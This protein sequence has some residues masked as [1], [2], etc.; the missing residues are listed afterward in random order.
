[1]VADADGLVAVPSL[2]EA[3][4]SDDVG[5]LTLFARWD[6]PFVMRRIGICHQRLDGTYGDPDA[7]VEV[8]A[9][10]GE[11]VTWWCEETET[12]CAVTRTWAA[13]ADEDLTVEV[14]RRTWSLTLVVDGV[15]AVVEEVPVGADVDLEALA[16][17]LGIDDDIVSWHLLSPQGGP[18]LG[19]RDTVS[20]LV[21]AG[22]ACVLEARF[23]PEDVTVAFLPGC[24]PGEVRGEMPDLVVAADEGPLALPAC[25]YARAGFS[26]VGW[27]CDAAADGVVHDVGEAVDVGA[28][29][30]ERVGLVAVWEPCQVKVSV[31]VLAA[32]GV[33]GDAGACVRRSMLT[34]END[35]DAA[36]ELAGVDVATTG[37][38][39]LV[40]WGSVV[41]DTDVAL[42]LE[43]ADGS[44]YDLSRGELMPDDSV[45][46]EEGPATLQVAILCETGTIEAEGELCSLRWA[47]RVAD[48]GVADGG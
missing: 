38:W 24:E 27:T 26:F 43:T 12:F 23:A 19:V 5:E 11:D 6:T 31:P 16:T 4:G 20:D 34:F 48:A 47:F 18:R 44:R 25:G 29:G 28:Y 32:L 14:P 35:S 15:E 13:P 3:L 10:A 2:E 41:E 22:D 30:A 8:E 39:R 36:V 42:A 45:C 1:M 9:V 21:G 7:F 37:P 46:I 33:D 40:E 17:R